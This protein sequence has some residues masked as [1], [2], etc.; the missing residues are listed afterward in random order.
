MVAHEGVYVGTKTRERL[1]RQFPTLSVIISPIKTSLG[2]LLAFRV[3]EVNNQISDRQCGTLTPGTA[4]VW[5]EKH[6][7]WSVT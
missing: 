2:G 3:K 4:L 1:L 7:Y 5:I 6:F